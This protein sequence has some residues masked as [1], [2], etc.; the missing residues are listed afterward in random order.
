MGTRGD[1]RYGATGKMERINEKAKKR[2]AR[3]TCRGMTGP[4][5]PCG[6]SKGGRMLKVMAISPERRKLTS[7]GSRDID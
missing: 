5:R 1:L 4:Q 7:V 2:L 6:A 3:I